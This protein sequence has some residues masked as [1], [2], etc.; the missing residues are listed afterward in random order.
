[1]GV[2]LPEN[3]PGALPWTW[4][5]TASPV[6]LHPGPTGVCG[7]GGPY[8]E[9]VATGAYRAFRVATAAGHC[10]AFSGS[11]GSRTSKSQ[12]GNYAMP[13]RAS[14]RQ[15]LPCSSGSSSVLTLAAH[16]FHE[17][18]PLH[19]FL[20]LSQLLFAPRSLQQLCCGPSLS[21]FWAIMCLY[22]DFVCT[23]SSN[24][25]FLW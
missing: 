21:S 9:T 17:P 10:G 16:S 20:L 3:P 14:A 24:H 23:Q 6:S 1:M 12:G 5:L 18:L 13:S 8:G 4:F 7:F 15:Q 25:H 19:L 2:V 11:D 22:T